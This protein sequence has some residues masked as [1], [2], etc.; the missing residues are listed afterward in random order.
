MHVSIRFRRR[1]CRVVTAF[2]LGCCC[3]LASGQESRYY[4]EG[5]VTYKEIRTKVQQPV[6]ELEYKDEQQTFYRE[7]YVTDMQPSAQTIYQPAVQYSW[8]PRWHGWWNIIDG[9]HVAYHLVPRSTWQP[10]V[11]NY[12]VPITRREVMPE[13]RT[14]RVAVPKLAMQ[15]VESVTRVAVGPAANRAV[16][17]Q[18]PTAPSLAWNLPAPSPVAPVQVAPVYIPPATAY[19]YAPYSYAYASPYG[20]VARLQSDPPRYS[21]GLGGSA[22]QGAWQARNDSTPAR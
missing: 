19:A 13:T 20:G 10:Q 8:E 22:S 18:A 4:E 16:M 3:P 7:R 2:I 15:E 6:R 14:V 9:P 17:A 11:V 5:G 12:Q 21:N 1:F